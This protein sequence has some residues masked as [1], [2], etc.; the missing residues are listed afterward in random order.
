MSKARCFKSAMN[1]FTQIIEQNKS[2]LVESSLETLVTLSWDVIFNIP[3][4]TCHKIL[5]GIFTQISIEVKSS[6]KTGFKNYLGQ[7]FLSALPKK[8]DLRNNFHAQLAILGAARLVL[9][10]FLIN[11]VSEPSRQ[12]QELIALIQKIFDTTLIHLSEYWGKLYQELRTRDQNMIEEL[13]L[14]KNDLQR[15]LDVVYQMIQESPVGVVDCDENLNVLH[16]NPRAARL[17]GFL[18]SDI[19]K[20]SILEIFLGKSREVFISK[21]S[22]QREYIANF[23]VNI[24]KKNQDDFPAL[25]SISKIKAPKPGKMCYIISFQDITGREKVSSQ[26]QTIDRLKAISRLT[27]AM[28]HDIRNPLNAIGLNAE[29]IETLVVKEYGHISPAVSGVL[30]KVQSQIEQL[31]NSLNYYLAY[32]HLSHVSLAPTELVQSLGQ[33]LQDMQFEAMQKKVNLHFVKPA[34]SFWIMAD[35]LQLRRVFSNLLQ[36]SIQV[37]GEGGRV[38]VR[39]LRRRNRISVVI[40]DNGPGIEPAHL[41]RIFEPFFTTKHSGDG[42]GLYIAREIVLAHHGRISCKSEFGEGA[43]FT[44]TFPLLLKDRLI[45]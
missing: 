41:K 43:Q 34:G 19:L 15:Q 20:R 4:E 26:I 28:M 7:F 45:S 2:K 38:W 32:T 30:E 9:N 1:D 14:V 23:Q 35:W 22:S 42:L 10:H 40:R 29:I 33:Y 18:P 25:V 31:S 13:K 44:T 36:N 11:N 37:L 8:G 3:E 27:S 39:I 5:D 24:T 17:T 12:F 16:W 6:P 21:L